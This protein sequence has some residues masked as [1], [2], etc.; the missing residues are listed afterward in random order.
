MGRLE[1]SPWSVCFNGWSA[2]EQNQLE[3]LF[4]QGNGH[5][6]LRCAAEEEEPGR[7]RGF[8]AAGTFDTAFG[9][10]PE[11]PN[12]PDVCGLKV[13]INGELLTIGEQER[14]SCRHAL[15]L[16]NGLSVRSFS[17]GAEG[18]RG[19]VRLERFVSL[20]RLPLVAQRFTL[21][22][23]EP[24][25]I[26][27]ETLID[28]SVTNSGVQHLGKV[29]R[30]YL[31]GSCA[32]LQAETLQSG[33]PVWIAS[34]PRLSAPC[35]EKILMERRGVGSAFRFELA[36]GE[37]VVLERVSAVITGRDTPAP[38]E[39]QEEAVRCCRE[40][41]ELG[42]DHLLEESAQKWAEY[43][44]DHDVQVESD[45]KF[46]QTALRFAL[47][48]LRVMTPQ[49]DDRLNIG[50]KGLSGEAYQ[51]HTFWDTEMFLLAPWLYTQPEVAR[52]L[53]MYRW[54][55][56][57]QAKKKAC[58]MGC[59][60]AMFPWEGSWVEDGDATPLEG[61]PDVVTGK[62]IPIRTGTQEIHITADVA[63]AAWRY[64]QVTGDDDFWMNY[65]CELVIAAA[66]YWA[67]RAQWSQERQRW[68]LTGVIGPDEYSEDASNNAYTNLMAGWTMDTALE[69]LKNSVM[70]KEKK[71]QLETRWRVSHHM[72]RLEEVAAGL[73]RPVPDANGVIPQ[74]DTYCTLPCLDLRPYRSGE[75]KLL[76]DWNV[77]QLT[78]FRVSKQA[79]VAV[80]LTLF[81]EN[82]S[83]DVLESN[84]DYYE[85]L[86]VHDSSL[87]Y[88]T[89]SQLAA[90]CGRSD[91]AYE[92]FAKA[93]RVD[94]REGVSS[95]Q[96][97]HAAAMGGI[98][99]CAVLGFGGVCQR[100]GVLAFEPCL[101]RQ[102]KRLAFSM[103][104]KGQTIRVELLP[105]R[106]RLEPECEPVE[107]LLRGV[108]H[109]DE[110]NSEWP[111]Y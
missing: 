20:A 69:L 94:L 24:M 101:P 47:Y 71:E 73:Y 60:G 85:P 1:L 91:M 98:W 22:A 77:D 62:P 34:I 76:E 30:R 80:L 79:D 61:A 63:F 14:A 107:F 5:L 31:P 9:E 99:Q 75:R 110:R 57:E 58:S 29:L 38:K 103:R 26:E 74:D 42:F 23:Y 59:A 28:G 56:L 48:H 2:K 84:L 105:D 90:L 92:L 52:N 97:I 46:D 3:S 10:T 43:W 70:T 78:S 82:Y 89:Y 7:I 86:C 11:L 93:T 109:I 37:T 88:N 8:F 15:D 33:V 21:C 12:L 36:E 72:Q 96:G 41:S 100:E 49:M 104:W 17:L 4:C 6:G 87:S 27:L 83:R 50:A 25:K 54:R 35:E 44:K 68:E 102:W 51:G 111:L 66:L 81:A 18:K 67:T 53:L 64:W 106:L 108:R 45:Q 19:E 95:A 13:W 16:S 39:G 32:L 65:G 55:N 40:A